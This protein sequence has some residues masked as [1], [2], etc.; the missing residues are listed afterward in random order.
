MMVMPMVISLVCACTGEPGNASTA[1][2]AAA[3][4]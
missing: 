3:A 1:A 2:S 4:R